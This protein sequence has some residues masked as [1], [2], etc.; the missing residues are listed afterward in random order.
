MKLTKKEV[1]QKIKQRPFK[2]PLKEEV[3]SLIEENFD[4]VDFVLDH[5]GIRDFLFIVED[6]PNLSAF[7]ANLFTTINVACEKD[8]SFKK[9]LE[10]S[11]YKY[12]SDT[13]TSLKAIKEL[14]KDTERTL[15]VG[16]GFKESQKID[17][18]KFTEEIL[19]GKYTTQEEVLKALRDFPEWYANYAKD[20]NNISFITVKAENFINDVLKPLEKFYIQNQINSIL[21]KRR[22]TENDKLLLKDLTTYITN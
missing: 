7:T 1:W 9:N 16:V 12:N 21:L 6:T 4:R 3:F 8:Y 2:F 17:Q 18:A 14:F 20:P 13:S 5:V 11:L 10:L 15:Y 19:S 22:L